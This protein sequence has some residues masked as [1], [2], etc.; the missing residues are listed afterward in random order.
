MKW[1][2]RRKCSGSGTVS[3]NTMLDAKVRKKFFNR[4]NNK[5][6]AMSNVYPL[7]KK[8]QKSDE[9]LKYFLAEKCSIYIF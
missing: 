5:E 7:R 2:P 1:L 4:W 8:E 3:G 6:N 9:Y